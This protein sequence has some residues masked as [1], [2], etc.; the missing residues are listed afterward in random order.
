MYCVCVLYM[1]KQWFGG[2]CEL[3]ENSFVF[4]LFSKFSRM[5]LSYT[6]NVINSFFF[7]CNEPEQVTY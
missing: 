1:Y 5:S 4:S 3:M 6:S 7:Q 2:G